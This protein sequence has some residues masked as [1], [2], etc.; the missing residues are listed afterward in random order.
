MSHELLVALTRG[1]HV[2]SE[3]YGAYCVVERARVLRSRGDIGR[4]VFYRS[5]AKPIQA[6]AVV[7]SGAADRFGFTT[8]ELAM[9][10]GSHD[11]S[12]HHAGNAISMLRK[13]GE[14]ADLLHC[15]GHRSISRAVYETYVRNGYEWGRLEDN[16]SGKHAGMIGAAKAFGDDPATYHE[17]ANRVQQ[18]NLD[19]VSLLTGVPGN[20]IP[21]GIDGCG[22]PSFAVPVEAMARAMARFV[23]PDSLPEAKAA[24]AERLMEVCQRHPEMVAGEHRFDTRLIRLGGGKLLAKEGAEAVQTLGVAG[25]G[26]GFAVKIADGGRRAM[27]A[28]TAALLVE[29]GVVSRGDVS[30][31]YLAPVLSREGNPVG[32]LRVELG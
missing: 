18:A 2:E 3:H 32:E 17:P 9:V 26:L 16:C 12:P 1:N 31:K 27:Q 13:M 11:G 15:G 23:G 19:N 6:L 5:A 25:R 20:E 8:E 29:F 14:T 10:C 4:P 22:I 7:E 28:V 21:I 24:A 30:D